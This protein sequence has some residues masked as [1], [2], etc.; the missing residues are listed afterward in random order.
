MK[1]LISKSIS[2]SKK[3]ILFK[4]CVKTGI[5]PLLSDDIWLSWSVAAAG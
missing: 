3:E 5:I 2:A 4:Y 1:I